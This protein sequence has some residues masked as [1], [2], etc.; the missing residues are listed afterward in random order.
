VV[1]LQENNGV[2][3]I[4]I[5][6][7]S[8]PTLERLFSAG[9]VDDRPADLA[10]DSRI[11]FADSFPSGVQGIP[12]AGTRIPD[13][14]AWGPDGHTLFTADEGEE[15]YEGGR[16]WSARSASGAFLFDDGGTLEA[17]AVR[18]GHYPDGRSD[19]KGI[20][21]ESVITARYGRRDFLIVSSERGSFLAV[22][23]LDDDTE[24]RF[25][26]L[27]PT[28]VAP[29]GIL[30]IPSRNLL[31]TANE[32]DEQDG[33]ISIFQGVPGP[34]RP[35][36]DRPTIVSSGVEMPWGALSGLVASRHRPDVLY[37]IPDDALPSTIFRLAVGGPFGWIA[38]TTPIVRE[39][40]Q[41]LYDLEGITNDTSI[42]QPRQNAGFWL[43]S[44]GNAS[45]TRNVLV[46]VSQRGKVLREIFLPDGMEG[47]GR[48]L[49]SNGFEGVTVS[50]DR[51]YLLVAVQRP[52]RG[53]QPVN[54][55]AY[56]RIARYDLKLDRWEAF[57]YPLEAFPGTIGLSEVTLMGRT[58]NHEDLYAVIERDNRLAASA[59]LK[60]LYTFT[61][62]DLVPVDVATPVGP[63]ALGGATVTKTLLRDVLPLFT[64]FEKVEGLTRAA[65]GS[66]WI[67]LDNDGGEVESRL[68]RLGSKYDD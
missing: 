16:G 67:G 23:R 41:A 56:T 38:E 35:S 44:E 7:P 63:G 54:G 5:S 40:Q 32:G 65:D 60:R 64:P 14:I 30:A 43:A 61:L 46:Q 24:P 26:Q 34:W 31:I 2:A 12:T 39:G 42:A 9:V 33:T 17:T 21:A 37:S 62:E 49:T 68:V 13:A 51:R 28:G 55:I 52:F 3:V 47:P 18:F 22:Y 48:A 25:V 4:D 1:T 15:A 57:F 29:E 45:T 19:A 20:E 8:A 11:S 36:E 10:D 66:L 59:N 6:N 27:L 53:E 50:G 58:R